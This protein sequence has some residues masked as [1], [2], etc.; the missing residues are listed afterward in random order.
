MESYENLKQDYTN[1][2]STFAFS[3]AS[4]V[5][6]HTKLKNFGKIQKELNT[7]HSFSVHQPSRKN[8]PRRRVMCIGL[9]NQFHADLIDVKKYKKQN[10]HY[11]YLLTII[12]CLSKWGHVVP[13]KNKTATEVASA[14]EKVMVDNNRFC[15]YLQVDMGKEFYG[16]PFLKMLENYNIT[17]FSTYSEI[18]NSIA[19]RFNRTI[20]EKLSSYWTH[21]GSHRYIEALPRI[22]NNYNNSIHRSTKHKPNEVNKDNEMDVFKNLYP[23]TTKNYSPSKLMIGDIVRISTQKG[24]FS[25]GYSNNW[26]E[27]FYKI[28]E[29]KPTEPKHYVLQAMDGEEIYG[30]FYDYELKKVDVIMSDEK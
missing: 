11:Q 5:R 3:G 10:N 30:G 28:M 14:F 22:V 7:L 25:K 18:K 2:N 17:I 27:N 1:L 19:E 4:S 6:K 8:F 12:D 16:K 21:S 13:V 23:K 20:L 9:N 29:I 15:K 26:S 24:I